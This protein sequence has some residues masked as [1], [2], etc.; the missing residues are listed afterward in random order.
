MVTV[1]I[2]SSAILV[3]PINNRTDS[4]LT[5]AYSSLIARLQHSGVFPL[6]H[7]L[8]NEISN[9]MKTLITD[10]YK[11][12][13]ELV[14][15]GCHRRYAA[16]VAIRNS[17]SHFLSILAG[18]AEDFPIKL[19]DKLLPQAEITI[20]LLR[21]C[22]ST[23]MVSAYA[24]LNG[25]FDYNKMPLAPM[26]CKVQTHEKSTLAVHGIFTPSMVGTSVHHPSIKAVAACAVALKGITA[27]TQDITDLKALLDITA[28]TTMALNEPHTTD[29]VPRVQSISNLLSLP[30][31]QTTNDPAL[32]RVT[33]SMTNQQSLAPVAISMPRLATKSKRCKPSKPPAVPDTAPAR[34]TH[35]HPTSKAKLHAPPA[36]N[37]RSQRISRIPKPI[38]ILSKRMKRVDKEVHQ[39]LAVMDHVTGKLLNYCALLHHPAYH[40]DWTTSSANEFGRLANGVGGR[41]KGTN[42]IQFIR[43]RGIPKDRIKDVTLRVNDFGVKY[44]GKEHALHLKS[45]L[46]SYYPLSTDWTGNR[47]IRIHLD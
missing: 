5:R 24:H 16:E 35:S 8:D 27:P 20:N 23:P 39:A 31:V 44:V 4:E 12:T 40:D 11:M 36:T 10:T 42:T 9:A 17:K 34:N 13:Y 25:P 45:V 6:K 1:H 18:V 47:Y 38:P 37:T 15:P 22:N 28:A 3:K 29:S 21:Q 43:K 33:R 41:V 19:W 26:G 30:M 46:K 2:D 14:P 7:V 32:S